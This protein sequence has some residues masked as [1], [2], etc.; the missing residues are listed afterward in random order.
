LLQLTAASLV[1]GCLAGCSGDDEPSAH[2][3]TAAT[4]SVG[5]PADADAELVHAALADEQRLLG[6]V[7]AARAAHPSLKAALDPRIRIQTAHIDALRNSLAE[8][9]S[10]PPSTTPRLPRKLRA[11]DR[12]LTRQLIATSRRRSADCLAAE[13]G[14]LA[15]LLAS[16]AASHTVGAMAWERAR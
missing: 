8:P 5:G 14:A 3:S 13:S 10:Q 1:G 15:R 16:V 11:L 4:S 2:P 9:P 6:V 7:A 12:F